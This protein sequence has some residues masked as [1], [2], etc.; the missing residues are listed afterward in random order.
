MGGKELVKML[1][2]TGNGRNSR[3]I[4]WW[5]EY[6]ED[7]DQED[8][9]QDYYNDINDGDDDEDEDQGNSR[10]RYY[11]EEEIA[12]VEECA[13]ALGKEGGR[14]RVYTVSSSCAA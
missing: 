8:E 13:A 2:E 1:V 12:G 10:K 6:L 9:N 4:P 7:E 14:G 3:V 5:K 11:T